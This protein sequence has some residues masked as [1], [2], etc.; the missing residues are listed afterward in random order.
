MS[1]SL[2][3]LEPQKICGSH[4][5]REERA[6]RLASLFIGEMIPLLVQVRQ[7]FF[8]KEPAET[9]C[10]VTTFTEY[11]TSILRY[12][13][14]HIRHL[15]KGQNPASDK[16]DGSA[17]RKK[18]LGQPD[19]SYE[20]YLDQETA[21][22]LYHTMIDLPEWKSHRTDGSTASAIDYGLSYGSDGSG[23]RND[24]IS[25]IPPFL[26]N[27]ADKISAK[28]GMPVNYIQCH[29]FG[30]DCEVSPHPDP[31][32]MIVPMLVLGQERTFR[33]GG[34]IIGK[35]GNPFPRM[36]NQASM[37]NGIH[38]PEDEIL[39]QHGSLL[40]F[41]GGHTFHSML[42]AANDEKFNPNGF[43][44]R[45]SILFRW[46]TPAMREFGT[47][48]AIANGSLEQYAQTKREYRERI[49]WEDNN[50][51]PQKDAPQV[52]DAEFAEYEASHGNGVRKSATNMLAKGMTPTDVVGALVGMDIPE[53]TAEAAVRILTGSQLPPA[54]TS[55]RT[56]EDVL[57]K[58]V[59]RIA[60]QPY[61]YYAAK[62]ARYPEQHTTDLALIE[63]SKQEIWR[64]IVDIGQAKLAILTSLE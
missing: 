16:H 37:R 35:N 64:R 56:L 59:H 49:G 22:E 39:L 30:P 23:A 5:D 45:I 7:D 50:P 41:D 60:L 10:G 44:W 52:T 20:T 36:A 31:K 55:E 15:I 40:V 18:E 42:P 29:K 46:T 51:K 4:Q 54:H 24:E 13:E 57:D 47:R 27:I 26:K 32:N 2:A 61:G 43:E 58:L 8:D 53:P 33:V 62:F 11:C 9:I 63:L 28:V 21:T 19:W 34:K 12:S 14:G 25:E 17:H 1:T 6:Q 3:V 38:V 48:G